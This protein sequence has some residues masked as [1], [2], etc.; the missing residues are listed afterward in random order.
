MAE[1]GLKIKIGADVQS[2]I[3]NI[4]NLNT[5]LAKTSDA[6]A[7][8]GNVGMNKLVKGT[9]QASTALTNFGRVASDAP[10]GLIGI[11]NNIE[12]LVQSFVQLRKET[13]SGKAA[14]QA[15]TASLAGGGGLVLG[16]SI[17]TSALQFAQLGFDRWFKSTKETKKE[18]ESLQDVIAGVVGEI[19][20][21]LTQVT[22]LV[23]LLNSET[24]S[25]KL[26]KEAINELIRLQP[27]YF[28]GLS[29]EESAINS[30][31]EA[32]NRY[33]QAVRIRIRVATLEKQLTDVIGK[34]EEIRLNS[35]LRKNNEI[36]KALNKITLEQ[37]KDDQAG[38][39]RQILLKQ[40]SDELK[41]QN[42][43]A[44]K[45]SGLT[46]KENLLMSELISAQQEYN[47]IATTT[48]KIKDTNV[49]TATKEAN[50][51]DEIA[52][53][54]KR[55]AQD[56]KGINWDEQNRQIDGTKKRL[57]AAS[58]TLK[59]LYLKG[60][61]E[62]SDAWVQVKD[63][64]D[65]Y[66]IIYESYVRDKRLKE[67]NED[68]RDLGNSFFETL[69]KQ[70]KSTQTLIKLSSKWQENYKNA[71]LVAADLTKRNQE[72]ADTLTNQISPVIESLFLAPLEGK[73]IFDVLQDSVKSLVSEIGRL[74]IKQ[75]IYN[76][77]S[78]AFP[79]VSAFGIMTG[80][81]NTGKAYAR[82]DLF[83]FL[84]GRG[85]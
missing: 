48:N 9:N 74:I 51:Q 67:I 35:S 37:S 85:R 83:S 81:V 57:D 1:E 76:A 45:L 14:L 65:K 38:A 41:I 69:I 77:L 20:K 70:Q 54:I 40:K 4:N 7:D 56:I 62:T 8:T 39:A 68:L 80:S 59:T 6:A 10:F 78:K 3:S 58:E 23:S 28:K 19:S 50:V 22:K 71:T 24:S 26:K 31:N 64:F 29:D 12:P 21:E 30:I 44:A 25:R 49:K 52:E 53:I 18:T 34:K 79:T 43:E 61:Q 84:L 32:Y 13:G 46:S 75:A 47:Q 55:Y 5:T 17:L 11:A 60:V 16:I 15:L 36:S 72:L 33:V 2:A 73:N 82:G 63:D 42:E 66:L 27:E